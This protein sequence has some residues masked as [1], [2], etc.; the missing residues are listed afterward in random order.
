MKRFIAAAVLGVL[1]A[2]GL[3][4]AAS[5]DP[6]V[7]LCHSVSITVNGSDVVNDAACNTAP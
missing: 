2:L 3:A 6:S 5:A 1:A 7:T 4:S